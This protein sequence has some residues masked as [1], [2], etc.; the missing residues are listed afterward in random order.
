MQIFVAISIVCFFAL[1]WAGIALARHV[2]ASRQPNR[3]L[4]FLQRDNFAQHLFFNATEAESSPEPRRVPYQT[5][6][7]IAAKKSWNQSP[8]NVT[9]LPNHELR[10]NISQPVAE[11]PPAKRKPT[12]TS[13]RARS[14]R[15]DW[16]YFNKHRGDLADLYQ[17]PGIR[18]NSRN[19]LKRY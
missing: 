8:G 15:L 5:L 1:V 6:Q 14:E 4:S 9:A 7:D 11:A 3:T 2:R 10:S 13:R 12:Q 17:T 19:S 16:A 18:T